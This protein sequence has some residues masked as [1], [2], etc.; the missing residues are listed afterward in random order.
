MPKL[1]SPELDSSIQ[2]LG[3]KKPAKCEKCKKA[4]AKR[5]RVTRTLYFY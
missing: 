2:R 3:I 1:W 4:I 5:S